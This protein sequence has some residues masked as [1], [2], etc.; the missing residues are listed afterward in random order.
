MDVSCSIYS[1]ILVY[2]YTLFTT[3]PTNHPPVMKDNKLPQ[4]KLQEDFDVT[5]YLGDW[6]ELYRSKSI[7]FEKGADITARYGSDPEHPDRMTVTN[8]QTL[9]N[10]K[11]DTITG[12]AVRKSSETPASDLIVRF[13]WF[14][15]GK[16]KVI[17]TDYETYSIVYSS[18][19]ILFGLIK[20]EYCWVL[21]RKR[22]VIKDAELM[23]SIFKTILEETGMTKDEFIESK[24]TNSEVAETA[25]EVTENSSSE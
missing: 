6:Y 22:D 14:L 17:Q 7:C 12:Y 5:R 3:T 19:S 4:P 10:G 2:L 18:R 25:A 11:I 20:R 1:N 24:V 16:Y 15:R 21:A 23:D 8:L 13:N 9:D